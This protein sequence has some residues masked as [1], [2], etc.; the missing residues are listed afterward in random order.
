M[1]S[2]QQINTYIMLA[3]CTAVTFRRP[4]ALA[5]SNANSATRCDACFVINF[6]LCTT[7]STI[8][9]GMQHTHH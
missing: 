2:W 9:T 8:C 3:L 4:F 7:P 1:H 5:Y 6:I